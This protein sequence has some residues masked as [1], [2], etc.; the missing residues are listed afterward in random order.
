M[1]QELNIINKNTIITKNLVVIENFEVKQNVLLN[2]KVGITNESTNIEGI[3]KINQNTFS[4][5][6]SSVDNVVASVNVF[7]EALNKIY[8]TYDLILKNKDLILQEGNYNSIVRPFLN[9]K[10]INPNI[11][12]IEK[13]SLDNYQFDVCETYYST[14]FS[15][16]ED[17]KWND[18]TNNEL[19]E[20][21]IKYYNDLFNRNK[22]LNNQNKLKVIYSYFI[23]QNPDLTTRLDT[24]FKI[25]IP[26][27]LDPEYYIA[28]GSAIKVQEFF[29]SFTSLDKI[30]EYYI[31]FLQNIQN[32]INNNINNELLSTI[33]EYGN[34][35]DF[36][37]LK[38][39]Q[40]NEYPYWNGKY[41]QECYIKGSNENIPIIIYNIIVDLN[42]NYPELNVGQVI[43]VT[44]SISSYNYVAIVKMINVD[45]ILCFQ[46][47][48][49]KIDDYFEETLKINGDTKMNG[50]LRVQTFDGQ[51]IIETDNVNKIT[52][53]NNKVGIN[54]QAF[55]VE[56]ILD[57]D[58][59][60]YQNITSLLDDFIPHLLN[61][62]DISNVIQLSNI[63]ANIENRFSNLFETELK[64][65]KN[66]CFIL[67]IPIQSFINQ[68]D[69]QILYRPLGIPI[70]EKGQ[71]DQCTY[72]R[73]NKISNELCR[74]K[75]E[76]K[77][78]HDFIFSFVEL[79]NDTDNNYVCSLKGLLFNEN[80]EILLIGTFLNVDKYIIDQSYKNIFIKFIDGLSN[81][82]KMVNYTSLLIHND[83]IFDKII[84]E[85][86]SINSI[87]K[88]IEDNDFRGRF[89][90]A[91]N[92]TFM[93]EVD[94]TN[95]NYISS[96][97][98]LYPEWNG[99]NS[100]DISSKTTDINIHDSFQK[101]N[102]IFIKNF[103][104]KYNQNFF[105]VFESEAFNSINNLK[106]NFNQLINKNSKTYS[107]G[108][109]INLK[110]YID[111]SI[112][113]NGD[114][115]FRGDFS[116]SD[117]NEKQIF[118]INSINKTIGNVYKVGIG[119][120]DP[121]STLDVQDSGIDDILKLSKNGSTI[122]NN[123]NKII[124]LLKNANSESD[125]KQIIL[126]TF[127]L[128]SKNNYIWCC[129]INKDTFI[130]KD[131]IS[132]YEFLFPKWEGIAVGDLDDPSNLSLIKVLINYYQHILDTGLIFDN[133]VFTST[134]EWKYGKTRF[135]GKYFNYQ[136]NIYLIGSDLHIQDYD[137]HI[138]TNNN[139]IQL[140]NYVDVIRKIM[141]LAII[142][143]NNISSK[144]I[145]NYQ[146]NLNSL[147]IDLQ[148]FPDLTKNI[149]LIDIKDDIYQSQISNY[150]Y[151]NNTFSEFQILNLLESY[152]LKVKFLD[153][154][155]N[156]QLIYTSFK[157]YDSG[158]INYQDLYD[159][160]IGIFY[161]LK[162]DCK[163]KLLIKEFK[164]QDIIKPSVDI[165]GDTRIKGDLLLTNSTTGV[166]Y[167]SVDPEGKFIGINSDDRYTNYKGIFS[168]STSS[169]I[170]NSKNHVLISNNTNPNLVTERFADYTGDE[171]F[172]NFRSYSSAT[173]R[174]SSR[175][176]TFKEMY[177]KTRDNSDP[178]HL[179]KYGVEISAEIQDKNG[180]TAFMQNF[181][182]VIHDLDKNDNPRSAFV[183]R[184]YPIKDDGTYD[185]PRPMLYLDPDG[186]LNVENINV[187]KISGLSE[188]K[189]RSN[190]NVDTI[191]LSGSKYKMYVKIDG[192]EEILM[193]GNKEISR[194]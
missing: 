25:I 186:T 147:N 6:N 23:W 19:K 116:I 33:W 184:T 15:D 21:L 94:Y 50:K 181:G 124:N 106:I 174:R 80:N 127:P 192:D 117:S 22:K 120:I 48:P 66:Q 138:N 125:F 55:E 72:D 57:I 84:E 104:I 150:D 155:N 29:P 99:L 9:K 16:Y 97:Y 107:I 63:T 54:Q 149:Y 178:S 5:N 35:P 30:P 42:L 183:V 24:D 20:T 85:N 18:I 159:N 190:I 98:E 136:N 172:K 142:K 45:E 34:V 17:T 145:F 90:L 60:S 112:I 65:Y 180:F 28:I 49:I 2:N 47:T 122:F 189:E 154:I 73:F 1:E 121:K 68:E 158:I 53:F 179:A 110:D 32:I 102:E 27:I 135:A 141:G 61:S 153:L 86:D 38:C 13:F 52:I 26:D 103:G 164:L 165:R 81:V 70:L 43:F 168:T 44:Y 59:L 78:K 76:F 79:L 89:N 163:L 77:N 146:E 46:I 67:K 182:T 7:K 92:Y 36:N 83:E 111:K 170:I 167:T 137:L 119:T 118:N 51:N 144:D 187:G 134:Q 133:Y 82:N 96:Y 169:N 148:Q 109:G 175:L 74:M 143:I 166:N 152:N 93:N 177:E 126:D 4:D 140:F 129:K 113:T 108:T 71:F 69:I 139:N 173:I 31:L 132:I 64:D 162:I 14:N 39:I 11:L 130:G 105:I 12:Y 171:E 161:I 194:Q 91:S 87:T 114:V 8:Y 131:V 95:K 156:F 193:W 115:N 3:T 188:N 101:Y 128:Q 191:T 10:F 40:S 56:G 123:L 58:N 62:Y 160:F 157:E 41:I 151:N 176:F 37:Q 185:I 100:K 88:Y 75:K